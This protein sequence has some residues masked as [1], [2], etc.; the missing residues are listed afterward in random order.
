M[1]YEDLLIE[2]DT[3]RLIVKEK[4]LLANA[5]RIKGNRVAIK[6]DMTTCQKACTLAEELGH[7]YTS[8]GDIL[9][10]DDVENRKQEHRARMWAY[11]KAIG[12]KGI[13]ESYQNGC[14][15][16]EDITEYLNVTEEFF[17]EAL[18]AYKAK[19]GLYKQIDNYM[20]F[21]EP[22]GVLEVYNVALKER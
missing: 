12:L 15:T 7:H 9:N 2:A 11:N 1:N 22:L 19:Y 3:N 8:T 17:T 16:V 20:I 6:K 4:P 10:Q 21:F 18:N 14:R 5:G 13:L